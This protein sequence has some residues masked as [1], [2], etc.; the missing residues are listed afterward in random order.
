M[1]RSPSQPVSCFAALNIGMCVAD[2]E[3]IAKGTGLDE[4]RN[5]I[6]FLPL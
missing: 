6:V 5:Q 4:W 1:Y 3:I 2:L